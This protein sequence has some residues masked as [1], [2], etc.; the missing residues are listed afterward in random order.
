MVLVTTLYGSTSPTG[1]VNLVPGATIVAVF[2]H[3]PGNAFDNLLGNVLLFVPL[4]FLGVLAL[5]RRVAAV[6]AVACGL[7][8]VIEVSQ[9][10]LGH[11]WADIDDVLLNTTGAFLGA[12]AATITSP[13]SSGPARAEVDADQPAPGDPRPEEPLHQ[14]TGR[15]GPATVGRGLRALLVPR[16]RA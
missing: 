12:L 7:S 5:R 9:F 16:L 8:V 13:R 3:D 14:G 10:L 4:G 6:T 1:R 11:R 2:G 15:P